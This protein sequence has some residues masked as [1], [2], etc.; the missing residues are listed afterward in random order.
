M[1]TLV[2]RVREI[3]A[4]QDDDF[5]ENDT[6][7]YYI[8]SSKKKVVS[9]LS[10]Q[11]RG[12]TRTLRS[13]DQL[14]DVTPTTLG[15]FVS[16]NGY[17]K[18]TIAVPA[19]MLQHLYLQYKGSVLRELD[20]KKIYKLQWSNAIP[21]EHESYYSVYN[22]KFELYLYEDPNTI[23]V[24][25]YYIKEP[26]VVALADKTFSDIP[27]QLENAILYGSAL[28]ALAQEMV[29][30]PEGNPNPIVQIYQEELQSAIY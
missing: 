4:S 10:Q 7:L 27:K 23:D 1:P 30:N 13:L 16:T 5:F 2:E 18:G 28:M 22:D 15:T 25:I 24:D 3:I 19:T 8:N 6:L 29:Q 21:S 11:E 9:F 14:R 20:T 26:S 17:Y 12:G